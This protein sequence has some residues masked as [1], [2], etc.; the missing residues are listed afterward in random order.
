M[1]ADRRDTHSSTIGAG[2]SRTGQKV[3]Y[4]GRGV[5]VHSPTKRANC[6]LLGIPYDNFTAHVTVCHLLVPASSATALQVKQRA[7]IGL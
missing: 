7:W 4:L 6:R 1:C 5:L 2:L 3:C